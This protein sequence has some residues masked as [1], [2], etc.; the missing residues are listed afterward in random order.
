MT[1]LRR[2]HPEPPQ[3]QPEAYLGDPM[4]GI[5]FAGPDLWWTVQREDTGR[6]GRDPQDPCSAPLSGEANRGQTVNSR[7]AQVRREMRAALGWSAV[8][9]GNL[10]SAYSSLLSINA[11]RL[12]PGRGLWIRGGTTKE[13]GNYLFGAITAELGIPLSEAIRFAD[14]DERVDDIY[15]S[16]VPGGQPDNSA[17]GDSQAA[18][19]QITE[20]AGCPG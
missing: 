6:A 17:G 13:D 5:A 9:T 2:R 12:T 8:A 18:R 7:R 15:Q 14:P 20:G 3:P 10:A 1:A 19:N 4:I 16:V 11:A